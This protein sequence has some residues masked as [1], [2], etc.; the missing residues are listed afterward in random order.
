MGPDPKLLTSI[1]EDLGAC[2][3]LRAYSDSHQ[4]IQ[5]KSLPGYTHFLV[6]VNYYTARTVITAFRDILTATDAY[7][8]RELEISQSDQPLDAVLVAAQD[9]NSLAR[10]YPNYFLDTQEFTDLITEICN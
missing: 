10:G 2:A 7:A 9:V 1:E 4:T 3:A 5:Q 8:K 6:E